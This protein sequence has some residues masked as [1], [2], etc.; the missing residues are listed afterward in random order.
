MTTQNSIEDTK[1]DERKELSTLRLSALKFMIS[2][3][4][5]RPNMVRKIIGW[6]EVRTSLE[7]M[8]ELDKDETDLGGL[9]VWLRGVP[10]LD[11]VYPHLTEL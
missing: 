3:M 1:D 11:S 8:G 10:Y 5:A 7:G 2:L 9:E 4:D 6:T